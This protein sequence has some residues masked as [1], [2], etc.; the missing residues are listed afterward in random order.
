[1]NDPRPQIELTDLAKGK[2]WLKEITPQSR[3]NE[4]F[5]TLQN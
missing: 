5:I 3:S 1:M 4:P 2:Y